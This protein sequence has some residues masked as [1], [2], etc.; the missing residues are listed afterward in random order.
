MSTE[1][2]ISRVYEPFEK[3]CDNF[4]VGGALAF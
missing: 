3:N 1:E 2:I 4:D